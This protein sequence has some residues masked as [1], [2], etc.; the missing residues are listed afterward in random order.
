MTLADASKRIKKEF[1]GALTS[2]E[3]GP[4]EVESVSTGVLSL[5]RILG[6]GGMPK[7]RIVEIFGPPSSGKTWL[8][9]QLAAQVQKQ[10]GTVGWVDAEHSFNL[11]WARR[12][13]VDLSAEKLGLTHPQYAEE[14]LRQV[15]IYTEAGADLVVL[16][17]IGQLIPEKQADDELGSVHVAGIARLLT[18]SLKILRPLCYRSGAIVYLVN[19]LRANITGYGDIPITPGGWALEH[20][21]AIRL[22]LHTTA[23]KSRLV[24]E[25]GTPVGQNVRARVVKSNV[26]VPGRETEFA[27]D[28]RHG[29]QVEEDL[30]EIAVEFGLVRRSGGWTHFA[31]EKFHGKPAAVDFLRGHPGYAEQLLD[32]VQDAMRNRTTLDDAVG[33]QVDAE[34]EAMMTD[35]PAPE[36]PDDQA[37]VPDTLLPGFGDSTGDGATS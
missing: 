13:G 20:N 29:Y 24:V 8:A 19:Q 26:D 22:S 32:S 16:D 9:Y 4:I 3:E 37:E 35:A 25:S 21:C 14:A 11:D 31:D 10:G 33:A 5:D 34:V 17:S 15:Q 6:V 27:I 12:Q 1:E 30:L 36:A 2:A 18:T 7:G 23:A 28:F